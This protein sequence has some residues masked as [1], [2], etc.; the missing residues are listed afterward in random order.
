MIKPMI[1][2]DILGEGWYD[3]LSSGHEPFKNSRLQSFCIVASRTGS[4]FTQ[5]Q[6]GEYDKLIVSK[7]YQFSHM[8][9]ILL[10]AH[11][12]MI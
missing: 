6:N 3:Y 7:T 1:R 12:Q 8:D 2:L 11:G 9:N 5:L 4:P 10:L